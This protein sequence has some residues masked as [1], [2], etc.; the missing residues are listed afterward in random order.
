MPFPVFGQTWSLGVEEQFYLL[1]P[2]LVPWVL[3][4]SRPRPSWSS[5]SRRRRP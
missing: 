2:L 4:R 5:P 3:H 1:W